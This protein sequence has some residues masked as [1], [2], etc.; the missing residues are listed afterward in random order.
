MLERFNSP[1]EE[2]LSV[3]LVPPP[4]INWYGY[5]SVMNQTKL[6]FLTTNEVNDVMKLMN[7][8]IR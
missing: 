5:I 1:M 4:I 8:N 6:F 2:T 3:R 7:E